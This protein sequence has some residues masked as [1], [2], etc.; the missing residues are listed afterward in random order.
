MFRQ[1]VAE[2]GGFHAQRG[3][4]G[5]FVAAGVAQG[6]LQELF[7][8]VVDGGLETAH[9]QALVGIRAADL[10]GKNFAGDVAAADQ[11][12]PLQGVIQFADV[13]RP[14]V[15]REQRQRRRRRCGT[16]GRRR[17]A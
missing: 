17:C 11:I 16:A 7:F 12:R 3:G 9:G 8:G 10:G 15:T 13:A 4:G 5:R 1:F 14:V 2:G 6:L